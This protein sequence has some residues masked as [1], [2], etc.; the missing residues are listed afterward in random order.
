MVANNQAPPCIWASDPGD[1]SG[2]AGIVPS[3]S[4]SDL[5]PG[6]PKTKQQKSIF[7]RCSLPPSHRTWHVR[8]ASAPASSVTAS[9]ADRLAERLD[10]LTIRRVSHSACTESCEDLRG[11]EKT[12]VTGLEK[13]FA[14][15]KCRPSLRLRRAKRPPPALSCASWDQVE[16][17]LDRGEGDALFA[18]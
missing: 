7:K 13:W 6:H 14:L 16:H 1:D 5:K 12:Q 4:A 2:D 15:A 3:W 9:Q 17:C 18:H 11:N 10:T 8:A